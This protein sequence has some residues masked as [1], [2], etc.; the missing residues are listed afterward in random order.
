MIVT[1]VNIR[2]DHAIT[3]V[4]IED[5]KGIALHHVNI[6][7]EKGEPLHKGD[8]VTDLTLDDVDCHR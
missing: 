2:I 7:V 5:C 6:Q 8:N 1:L 4:T 3:G